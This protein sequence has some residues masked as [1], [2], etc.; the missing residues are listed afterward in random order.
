M[1]LT[2]AT[3]TDVDGVET[4][5]ALL[6]VGSTEQHGPHAPLGTDTYAA[7]AVAEAGAA[8][9]E[10]E[11]VV[12]P[13]IPVGVAAE[14]RSFAGTLWVTPETFRSYVRETIQSLV[15]HGFD[16]VVVVNGHGG[17][18][19]PLREVCARI[20]RERDAY[21]IPFTWF[22]T[23]DD[24][25]EMGHG[26][27]VETSLIRFVRPELVREDRLEE[28]REGGGDRW[29]EWIAGV[30]VAY[31]AEEFTASG[32]IGDPGAGDADLGE[33]LLDEAG[34]GLS[35]LLAAISTREVSSG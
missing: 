26:G 30:N 1:D 9:S 8:T 33:R 31:D 22:E 23:V 21:A 14:H 18:A 13:P 25:P 3:W 20:T 6:P 15:H 11:V 24:A 29:G 12:A 5:L 7:T 16:R 19:G 10:S 35:E 17:N 34:T 28:A 4:D 2:E 27:P 32:V